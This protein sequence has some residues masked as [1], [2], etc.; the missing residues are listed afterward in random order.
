[1]TLDR[2]TLSPKK[3]QIS[4]YKVQFPTYSLRSLI[5]QPRSTTTEIKSFIKNPGDRSLND[6]CSLIFDERE[7]DETRA[8]GVIPTNVYAEVSK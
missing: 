4:F 3:I 5:N 8:H 2:T 7:T 1:M 6:E